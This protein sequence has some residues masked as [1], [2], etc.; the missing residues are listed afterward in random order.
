MMERHDPYVLSEDSKL[1]L[2]L[3]NWSFNSHY[4]DEYTPGYFKCKWCGLIHTSTQ[5][6][7]LDRDLCVENPIVKRMLDDTAKNILRSI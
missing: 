7:F 4:W 3:A 1:N 6:W 2:E 5:G